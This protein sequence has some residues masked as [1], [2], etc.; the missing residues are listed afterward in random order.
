LKERLLI[1]E[2]QS[3]NYS[4]LKVQRKVSIEFKK[5]LPILILQTVILLGTDQRILIKLVLLVK[6]HSLALQ[7]LKNILILLIQK[8]F[9]DHSLLN[10][11][12]AIQLNL[13]LKMLIRLIMESQLKIILP[14]T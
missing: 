9:L 11:L 3:L 8:V 2:I 1:I 7:M 6:R 10:R 13:F 4:K 12:T 5:N 14:E